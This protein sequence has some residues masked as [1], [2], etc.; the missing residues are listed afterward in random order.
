MRLKDSL[1]VLAA[2]FLSGCGGGGGGGGG[3]V[4]TPTPPATPPAPAPNTSVATL[5]SSQTFTTDS[6][7]TNVSYNLTSRTTISGTSSA[8]AISISY[9]VATRSYTVSAPSRS[10]VFGPGDVTTSTIAG[11]TRYRKTD[12]TTSDNLTRVATPYTGSVANQYVQL[13]YWQRNVVNGGRQDT[14]FDT[15]IFGFPTLS[16]AVPRSGSARYTTD[17]FGL[18]ST[19]GTEPR[20]FQGAG[21]FDIDFQ[22]GQYST[23]TSLTETGLVSG[24]GVLGGGIELIGTG[25]LS[26]TDGSFSGDIIYGGSSVRVAGTLSGRLF[27]PAAQELGASFS[28]SNTDGST[29]AG[30]LTAQRTTGNAGVNFTLTNLTMPQFFGTSEALLTVTTFDGV[31]GIQARSTTMGSTLNDRTSGNFAYAPGTSILPGGEFTVTAIVP[32]PAN[33]TTYEKTFADQKVRLELFKPGSANTQLAL[34][35]ASFGRWSSTNKNNVVNTSSRVFFTY[36]LNTPAGLLDARTG[37]ATYNGIVAGGGANQTTSAT[38]DVAGTSRFDVN[39]STQ[40]MSGAL[41]LRGTS[42]NGAGDVDFGSY[43]FSGRLPSFFRGSVAAI[44]RG[45]TMAGE[46]TSSFFGPAGEEIGGPFVLTT[47]AGSPVAGTLITGV[48][49]ARRQ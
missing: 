39:F 16:T 28:A 43:D 17:V 27:G 42:T 6:A 49:L 47:P 26:G 8:Q 33:F 11:E 5:T 40:A 37:T 24:G 12:G 46:L 20:V 10:Q 2:I 35:Y 48:A 41:A 31:P 25:R 3:V 30:S 13:A 15:L 9:D 1:P 29:V 19:P 34:T 21:I 14:V 45:G 4:S 7:T 32:G 38:Y 22:V 36:G 23:S 44:T 18:A